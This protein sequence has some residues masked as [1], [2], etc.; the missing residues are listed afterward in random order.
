[1]GLVHLKIVEYNTPKFVVFLVSHHHLPLEAMVALLL[2]LG[3]TEV[4][5][6]HHIAC[7]G[8]WQSLPGPCSVTTDQVLPTS[9]THQT[10]PASE[11]N[12]HA[13]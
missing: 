10:L 1:M 5:L 8:Q 7:N 13:L 6:W 11:S 4:G 12:A 2:S 9:G 3:D